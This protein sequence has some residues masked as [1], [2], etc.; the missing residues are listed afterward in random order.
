VKQLRSETS[1][2]R[3]DR[4]RRQEH[5]VERRLSQEKSDT[6]ITVERNEALNMIRLEGEVDINSATA[7]KAH[8][9]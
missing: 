6:G 5:C 2:S 4:C 3:P 7:L 9:V 8:L 1:T